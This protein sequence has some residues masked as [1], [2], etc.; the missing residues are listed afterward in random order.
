MKVLL[1]EEAGTVII[2]YI[3]RDLILAELKITLEFQID[4]NDPDFIA[5]EF[6]EVM[7]YQAIENNWYR[8]KH[9]EIS[10]VV[11]LWLHLSPIRCTARCSSL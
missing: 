7:K 9:T 3:F 8:P 10:N 2:Y 5:V 4:L 11:F 1:Q 6:L